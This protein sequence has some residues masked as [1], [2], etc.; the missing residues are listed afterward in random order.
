VRYQKIIMF[1]LTPIT[2]KLAY[3]QKLETRHIDKIHQNLIDSGSVQLSN[4]IFF[5]EYAVLE[6]IRHVRVY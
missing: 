4:I 6:Y 5:L 3:L 1:L 2:R